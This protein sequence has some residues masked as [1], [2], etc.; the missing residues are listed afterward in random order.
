MQV[1]N[2]LHYAFD[3]PPPWGAGQRGAGAA[4]EAGVYLV[5]ALDAAHCSP[6]HPSAIDWCEFSGCL[7]TF[8]EQQNDQKFQAISLCLAFDSIR[9]D[10]L[11]ALQ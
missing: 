2:L 9:F 4:R 3:C 11:W 7:P 6:L 8:I 10:T 5:D 1:A